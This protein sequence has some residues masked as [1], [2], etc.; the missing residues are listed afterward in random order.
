MKR[1]YIIIPTMIGAQAGIIWSYD[2]VDTTQP[3][4]DAVPLQISAKQCNHLAFCLWYISPI[5][6]LNDSTREIHY[7]LLGEP[8]KWTAVSQQR[9]SSIVTN[10]TNNE[11]I[12]T[13]QG[14]SGEIVPIAVFHSVI[15]LV[16][17]NCSISTI[18]S[19]AH[20][21]ITTSNVTC[22]S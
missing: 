13:V 2:E 9:F 15:L 19:Q 20:V 10:T 17:V 14:I 22:S 3:F 6:S 7:A 1:D 11:V 21:I 18:D 8:N 16:T 5:Q 4:N 12:I